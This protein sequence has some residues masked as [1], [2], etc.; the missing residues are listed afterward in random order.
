[1][2]CAT[3][4]LHADNCEKCDRTT[5]DAKVIESPDACRQ[6]GDECPVD[7]H[8]WGTTCPRTPS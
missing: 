5:I 3:A 4:A 7:K 1:M 8:A 6:Y 2:C